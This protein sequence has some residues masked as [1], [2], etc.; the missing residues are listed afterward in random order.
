MK[1]ILLAS[2]AAVGIS[3]SAAA[4][5]SAV[6]GTTV[7]S[8]SQVADIIVTAR[9]RDESLSKVPISIAV[10]SSGALE[11]QGIRS[12]QDLQTAVPGLLIQQSG[13][14][15]SINYSIR[16]QTVDQ[17]TGSPPAVLP[18]INEF[19]VDPGAASSFFDLANVQVLKG[20]QGTLFGRNTTG[21]AVLYTTVQPTDKLN[22]FISTRIANFDGR[23]VTF[24]LTLPVAPFASLRLAGNYGDGGGYVKNLGAYD[25][26][27]GAGGNF[28]PRS[29]RLG[30]DRN[31]AIR[32]T[33]LLTPTDGIKNTTIVQ[34]TSDKG[35]SVPGLLYTSCGCSLDAP[36]VAGQTGPF[37]GLPAYLAW[38]KRTNTETYS[39]STWK[40]KSKSH[41][42]SNNT[43]IN[44]GDNLVLKNIVGTAYYN[45][46]FE[47]DIDATPWHIYEAA[48]GYPANHMEHR[49]FSEELQLQGKAFDGKLQ[50]VA[51]V[52]YSY[53]RDTQDDHLVVYGAI[54]SPS[55]YTL[56]DQSYAA[57]AQAAYSISNQVHLTG[58]FRYTKDEIKGFELPGSQ[59]APGGAAYSPTYDQK[60]ST[61]FSKP[62]WNVS[63][64]YQIKPSLLLYV[65]Q[66]GSWRAGGFNFSAPPVSTAGKFGGNLFLPETAK[67]VELG[68]KF[69]GNING[70]RVTT[71]FSIYR[72]WI[73]NVQRATFISVPF[74]AVVTSNVPKAQVTGQEFDF[75]VSP[76]SWLHV[77]GQ[78]SHVNAKFTDPLVIAFGQSIPY[79]P[80]GFSPKWS[81]SA[82][83]EISQEIGDGSSVA[84]RGDVFAQ[85]SFY[86]SNEANTFLP[87]TKVA[88]YALVNGRLSWNNIRGTGLALA[89]YGKNLLDKRYFVGGLATGV[90]LGTNS[91]NP[92]VPRSYG[93]ELKY[94]F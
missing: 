5:D 47:A 78:L 25:G 43:E 36:F 60:Q 67:D 49:Q 9:R 16:G 10:L 19:Q 37:S 23:Q 54:P 92:G 42:V 52:Y 28:V 82:F 84:L 80:Y 57:F 81:G 12:E 76:A 48:Q 35:T 61:S 87:G 94:A 13:S 71:N 58:G 18:Y 74:P 6:A 62:S 3:T 29:D 65:T 22:G 44:L 33:L 85:S 26:V 72:Q 1:T 32:A 77:G 2:V 88:G 34:V 73:N 51:G 4:Q 63:L 20:P 64:D 50:Y 53:L 45:K 56:K 38:Q 39:N 93:L 86:F 59:F 68:A 14:S 27:L 7:A 79:G 83:S 69:N 24:G 15:N 70:M 11:T 66:R 46:N 55:I 89:V 40:F 30:N 90:T 31:K 21:G 91:V 41:F 75:T 8:E 17:F